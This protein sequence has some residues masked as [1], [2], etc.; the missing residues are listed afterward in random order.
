MIEATTQAHVTEAMA[1]A[2][3]ERAKAFAGFWAV[4]WKLPTR[5][6]RATSSRWA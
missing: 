6:Y 1:R 4:L 2:H 3:R 5:R